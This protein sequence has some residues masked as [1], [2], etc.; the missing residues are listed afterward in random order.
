MSRPVDRPI[1]QDL[2]MTGFSIPDAELLH[3]EWDMGFD[4]ESDM[5]HFITV[6]FLGIKPTRVSFDG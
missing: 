1:E 2:T 5:S 4:S 3:T 6:Y